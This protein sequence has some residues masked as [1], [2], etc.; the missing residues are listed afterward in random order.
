MTPDQVRERPFLQNETHFGVGRLPRRGQTKS[1]RGNGP[2]GRPPGGGAGFGAGSRPRT[3]SPAGPVGRGPFLSALK[4]SW[5]SAKKSTAEG[6]VPPGE[7]QNPFHFRLKQDRG[8]LAA[9]T[10]RPKNGIDRRSADV[11]LWG[12]R[13][14]Q[15][16]V[17]GGALVGPW[18]RAGRESRLARS[19]TWSDEEST[20]L[21]RANLRCD[22]AFPGPWPTSRQSVPGRDR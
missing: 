1:A 17:V 14:R 16:A 10:T 20:A 22:R 21:C 9:P 5:P 6:R 2:V 12:L 13:S 3:G 11:G 19:P 15:A 7:K 8:S 4:L 18:G